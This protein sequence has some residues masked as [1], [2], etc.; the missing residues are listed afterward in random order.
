MISRKVFFLGLLSFT[1]FSYAASAQSVVDMLLQ[2]GVDGYDLRKSGNGYLA[3][4]TTIER[5]IPILLDLPNG[6]LMFEDEGTGG[7]IYQVEAV[8]LSLPSGKALLVLKNQFFDGVLPEESLRFYMFQSGKLQSEVT[9]Q[10][11]PKLAVKD[12]FKSEEAYA[13]FQKTKERDGFKDLPL[14]SVSYTLPR[15]GTRLEAHLRDESLLIVRSN[16]AESDLLHYKSE[17]KTQ[18]VFYT[19]NKDKSAFREKHFACTWV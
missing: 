17:L 19:L 2:V 6:Y 8:K 13:S 5:D 9:K 15:Y 3:Y 16:N 4:E 12:F 1:L 11:L 18:A 14:L 7:G 10:Y